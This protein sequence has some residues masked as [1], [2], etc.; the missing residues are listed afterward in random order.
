MSEAEEAAVASRLGVVDLAGFMQA[1]PSSIGYALH[2]IV[3]RAVVTLLAG[4]GG[5]GKSSCALILAAHGACG[6]SWLGIHPDGQVRTVFLSLEDPG[7]LVRYRL[8][9]IVEAYRLTPAM[10]EANLKILDGTGGD[11]SLVVET[12]DYGVRHLSATPL[13][14]ELEAACANADLII[15]DNASDAYSGNENERRSVRTFLRHL[16]DIARRNEAGMVLLAHID[17]QA[18]RTGSNGNTYSGSTAWH[19]SARSRLA[20]LVQEDGGVELVH[21]KNNLGKCADPIHLQWNEQGVL[22]PASRLEYE[23]AA[24]D[25]CEAALLVLLEAREVEVKVK[26]ST[27]GSVTA[28]HSVQH[29]AVAAEAFPR[30]KG[31]NRRFHTALASL[32]KDGLIVKETY[33]DQNRNQREAWHL[34]QTGVNRAQEVRCAVPPY[35]PAHS[36]RG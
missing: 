29:L 9:R 17:K 24:S 22:V 35:P 30:D 26:T 32:A 18:A 31:G 6:E 27:V 13:L 28:W 1:S 8:R 4:H 5:A 15:V 21:E 34:T 23:Q 7:D 14:A 25:D 33:R 20:L 19:N 11:A 10:I 3:P 36:T 12:N 2:P 16:T